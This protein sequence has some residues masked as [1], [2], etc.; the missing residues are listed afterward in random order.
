L[1]SAVIK[2]FMAHH[3]GMSLLSLNNYLNDF[4]IQKRFHAEP[5]VRSAQLLLEEKVVPFKDVVY[6]EKGPVRKFSLPD[7]VLP[8][9]HILSN[10]NYSVMITDRGT[11]YSRSKAAAVTR[12]RE[13][14][15]LDAYGM[16]FYIRN[17]ETNDL[18]SA[19]YSPLN[20]QPEN[21]EVTFTADKARFKRRD[22]CIET[23]TEVN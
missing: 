2:S 23:Q 16:F 1:K 9:V 12:W 6:K 10:G 20:T 15:I 13:D 11:G 8:K 14:S 21:Y 18:W 5:V 17:T 22:G 4:I 3:Q 7:P 19:A